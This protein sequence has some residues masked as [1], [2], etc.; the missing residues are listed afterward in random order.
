MTKDEKFKQYDTNH[1]E[2]YQYLLFL[3]DN[4]RRRGLKRY[5]ISPLLELIRWEFR[6]NRGND[7]FKIQ[8]DFKPW[9][10]R[11]IAQENPEFAEFF[12]FRVM[13]AQ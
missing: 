4:L 13:R 5:G 8:N 10:A 6:V 1:P 12:E 2:V 3:C 11:K 9:Y 7:D